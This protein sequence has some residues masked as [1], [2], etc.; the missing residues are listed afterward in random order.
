M[1][2]TYTYRILPPNLRIG[3]SLLNRTSLVNAVLADSIL[4]EELLAAV[5]NELMS[6]MISVV[7][8]YQY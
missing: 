4:K 7:R 1:N 5:V 6:V 3:L 8:R 2:N